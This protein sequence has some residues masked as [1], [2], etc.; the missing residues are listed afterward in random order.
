MQSN[1]IKRTI[2]Y[3]RI[4]VTDRCNL[5]CVYCMPQE[6]LKLSPKEDVLT[7]E[8]IAKLARIFAKIGIKKIP[9]NSCNKKY[10]PSGARATKGATAIAII[11]NIMEDN[12][13]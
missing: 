2:D 1:S 13:P 5:R 4:S 10:K 12:F 11:A 6:G 3:L 7:L 9:F 8:E